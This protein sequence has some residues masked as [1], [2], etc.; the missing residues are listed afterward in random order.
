[1]ILVSNKFLQKYGRNCRYVSSISQPRKR[2]SSASQLEMPSE[3]PEVI[4]EATLNADCISFLSS[5]QVP[6]LT[7]YFDY[8]TDGTWELGT[9]YDNEDP[10]TVSSL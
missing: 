5:D 1:M 9:V 10:T 2:D 6:D 7:N 3:P 4:S 8:F